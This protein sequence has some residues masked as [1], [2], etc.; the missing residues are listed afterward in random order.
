VILPQLL[1]RQILVNYFPEKSS[2]S[3]SIGRENKQEKCVTK[4]EAT[5]TLAKAVYICFSTN[6][7]Y[8]KLH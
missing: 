2:S 6:A 8:G 3:S 5:D 4:N 1:D 7:Y